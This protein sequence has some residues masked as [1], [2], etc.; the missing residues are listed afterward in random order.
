MIFSSGSSVSFCEQPDAD[1]VYFLVALA[2][3][4][5]GRKGE[6]RLSESLQPLRL[7]EKLVGCH[8]IEISFDRCLVGLATLL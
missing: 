5:V 4:W 2:V 6:A 1:C 7:P 3:I 8:S